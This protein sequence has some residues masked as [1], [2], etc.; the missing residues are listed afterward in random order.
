MLVNWLRKNFSPGQ[1]FALAIIVIS[2]L[3]LRWLQLDLRPVHHD[4]SLHSMYGRYF[5]DFPDAQF[6]KYD[7]MMHGPTIYNV[8]R[9]AY[10]TFHSTTW[11]AR[12]FI[13]LFGSALMIS[14][15]LFRAHL[16]A[17]AT[18][19]LTA[20]IALSP[21]M[22]YWSRFVR[23]DCIILF[24]MMT[25]IWAA[26][27]APKQWRGA[28]VLIGF[29]L[30]ACLKENIFVTLAIL[31][32]WIAFESLM[33]LLRLLIAPQQNA[34][35]SKA[36]A[37]NSTG[38]DATT[39]NTGTLDTGTLKT[40]ESNPMI[41]N[42]V[43][44]ISSYPLQLFTGVLA[45]AFIF[46]YLFSEGFRYPRGPTEFFTKSFS[47]WLD[48]HNKERIR[49]PFNFHVYTLFWYET[50]IVVGMIYA[51]Y[52]FMAAARISVKALS[53]Y[54]V[55]AALLCALFTAGTDIERVSPWRYINLKDSLDVFF[56]VIVLG[57][58]VLV[59]TW[60]L[61]RNE[62]V[63]AFWSYLFLAN[64]F[65]YSYLGEKVPWLTIYPLVTA[66][67]YGAVLYSKYEEYFSQAITVDSIMR[68]VAIGC[69]VFAFTV[70]V[71][72]GAGGPEP[73]GIVKLNFALGFAIAVLSLLPILGGPKFGSIQFG[74]LIA[75]T[76]CI[77]SVR[78]AILTN[79]TYA[80][81]ASEYMSQVH[82]TPDFH[83][84]VL[85]IKGEIEA[86]LSGV[87]PTVCANG[88]MT[89]PIT[90]YFV[91]VSQYMFPTGSNQA[92]CDAAT[93]RFVDKDYADKNQTP[94][95]YV[96]L[97]LPLR[98]WWVPD[99]N[100]ITPRAFFNYAL[101]H[102]PWSDTGFSWTTVYVKQ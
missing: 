74:S 77:W 60:H 72:E 32:G 12:A 97:D 31:D 42:L 26:C 90:W 27:C 78:A 22:I 46:Y 96:R 3:L 92:Q 44:S 56:A 5:Y 47:Y 1:L 36:S 16:S 76:V 8:M 21:S 87:K 14:P 89:W 33:W 24:W 48:Q 80:G 79:Y 28:L 49:G 43:R 94:S 23:E 68:A 67:I 61:L 50:P 6:Y 25:T 64:F 7:P 29:T 18:V 55:V 63:L 38:I 37:L 30:Q 39:L 59:P 53:G 81:H 57:H 98:G 65:T 100:K 88:E 15:L 51:W 102:T 13:C 17:R 84:L 69:G 40:G 34:L 11:G 4:E 20:I 66:I 73:M 101:N 95:G 62:R 19:A 86:P 41:Y 82:T 70:W 75:T 54:I 35:P 99:M 58:A 45:S 9:V 10:S 52:R 85:K 93:Y 91:G 71:T 83:R 2:G